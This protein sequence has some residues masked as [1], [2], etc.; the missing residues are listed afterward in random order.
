MVDIL[1]GSVT[2]LLGLG[3]MC[4]LAPDRSRASADDS[5]ETGSSCVSMDPVESA[6]TLAR[7]TIGTSL[8]GLLI[9]SS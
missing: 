9:V 3:G 6:L 2:F 7:G 8:E 5:M 4:G 1:E